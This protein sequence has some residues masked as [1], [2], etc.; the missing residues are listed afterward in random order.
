MKEKKNQLD[1]DKLKN[2]GKASRIHYFDIIISFDRASWIMKEKK[3][4]LDAD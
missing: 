3:N 4:Q 1:A 2:V